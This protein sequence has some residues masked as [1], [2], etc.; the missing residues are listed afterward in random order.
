MKR[1]EA[2]AR[3]AE[4]LYEIYKN[5]AMTAEQIRA[6]YFNSFNRARN[7]LLKLVSKGM[8]YRNYTTDDP[9]SPR[10]KQVFYLTMAAIDMLRKAGFKT[11]AG[12]PIP[13][14]LV[15]PGE[16]QLRHDLKLNDIIIYLYTSGLVDDYTPELFL[17]QV[18]Y[19]EK[20]SYRIPD[21]VFKD[22]DGY[23]FVELEEKARTGVKLLAD[24]RDYR[25]QYKDFKKI[26]VVS[27]E[28]INFYKTILAKSALKNYQIYVFNGKKLIKKHP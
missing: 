2:E 4:I 8:L 17:R 22:K 18:R 10:A 26:F 7:Y 15:K 9:G 16:H 24:I 3:R 20:K 21:I 14:Y 25:M 5:K 23:G 13:R 28:R 27:E 11:G 6:L 19:K 1:S 12:A